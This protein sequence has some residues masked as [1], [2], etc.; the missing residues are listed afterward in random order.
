MSKKKGKPAPKKASQKASQKASKKKAPAAARSARLAATTASEPSGRTSQIT[1]FIFKT[2]SGNR[3]RTSPQRAYAGPGHVEWTV[4]NL[5]D[6]SDV[7]VRITWPDGGPFGKEINVRSWQR[8][9]VEGVKP[10]RY[11]YVVHALDA[12]ED[13]ELEIPEM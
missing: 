13:P 10:G 8:E 9:S 6:G 4:V 2:G 7:P 1:I 5:I 3:I 11:K 12:V